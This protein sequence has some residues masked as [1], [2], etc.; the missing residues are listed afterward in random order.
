MGIPAGLSEEAKL[1]AQVKEVMQKQEPRSR[2]TSRYLAALHAFHGSGQPPTFHGSFIEMPSVPEGAPRFDSHTHPSFE[3]PSTAAPSESDV[4]HALIEGINLRHLPGFFAGAVIEVRA[5]GKAFNVL[6]MPMRPILEHLRKGRHVDA[7]TARE[8]AG[9]AAE[10][11]IGF[12]CEFAPRGLLV[13]PIVTQ[14]AF[15]KEKD[16]V[17]ADLKP[18][19]LKLDRVAID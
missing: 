17:P 7:E 10:G 5:G 12:R 19:F 16:V 15:E 4:R 6:N 14:S 1:A 8:A 2:L 11:I 3:H 13:R 9:R 18:T